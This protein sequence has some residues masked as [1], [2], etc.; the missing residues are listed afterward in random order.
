MPSYS[1]ARFRL[2]SQ[3]PLR[4]HRCPFQTRA[5]VQYIRAALASVHFP[6]VVVSFL[7]SSLYPPPPPPTM[8][9]GIP[10]QDHHRIRHFRLFTFPAL[11]SSRSPRQDC[12]P[13]DPDATHVQLALASISHPMALFPAK[14]TF[15]V[16]R[17]ASF[18]T[19][20]DGLQSHSILAIVYNVCRIECS[21]R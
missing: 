15:D 7:T 12:I 16:I 13:F 19:Y 3:P 20:F 6:F 9:A 5:Q 4:C 1:S 11:A 18:C 10:V 2:P 17:C 14:V 8:H 21:R